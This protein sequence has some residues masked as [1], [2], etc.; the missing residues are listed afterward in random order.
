MNRIIVDTATSGRWDYKSGADDSL[1]PHMVRLSWILEDEAGATIRDASHLIRLPLGAVTESAAAHATGIYDHILEAEGIRMFDV[2]SEF[3]DAL[4][5]DV[6]LVVAFNWTGHRKVL[7]RSFRYVG[8]ANREWPVN[9]DVMIKSTDLVKVPAMQPGKQYKWPTFDQACGILLNDVCRPT[10]APVA[11]GLA[12][13]RNVR[14][15][16]QYIVSAEMA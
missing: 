9:L 5:E 11:D 13:V 2:L 1:Q 16:Y 10:S 6:G 3:G 14:T 15:I 12:R 7:D 8:M 4:G